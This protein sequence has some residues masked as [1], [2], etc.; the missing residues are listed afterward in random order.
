[1]G[2]GRNNLLYGNLK[3]RTIKDSLFTEHLESILFSDSS[4]FARELNEFTRTIPCRNLPELKQLTNKIVDEEYSLEKVSQRSSEIEKT[5]ILPTV[6]NYINY[7]ARYGLLNQHGQKIIKHFSDLELNQY[8]AYTDSSTIYSRIRDRLQ[9]LID[10]RFMRTEYSQAKTEVNKHK[11][12]YQKL[13]I[14]QGIIDLLNEH[15]QRIEETNNRNGSP[16][17][18]LEYP[19]L[20]RKSVERALFEQVWPQV[21]ASLKQ[22]VYQKLEVHDL[23]LTDSQRKQ[24]REIADKLDDLQYS[25][26]ELEKNFRFITVNFI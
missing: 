16:I 24:A 15:Y 1:M 21:G 8:I 14:S 9:L 26:P 11:W 10:S 4:S 13:D 18:N 5:E 7:L 3:T 22:Q 23:F 20:P 2:R 17:S 6:Y 25:I 19:D 12:D